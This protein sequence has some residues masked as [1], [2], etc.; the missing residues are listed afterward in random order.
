MDDFKVSQS[1]SSGNG[2]G[3]G[4][5]SSLPAGRV[6]GG[7]DAR[8]AVRFDFS[9]NSNGCGPCPSAWQAVQQA[10]AR[11]YPDP[12]YHALRQQLA[13]FHGVDVGRVLL[14]ASASEFIFRITGWV[15]QRGGR[16]VSLPRHAYGDYAHAAQA[17]G[18]K[19]VS[20]PN[21]ADLVWACEPSSPLGHAHAP[22]P[23]GFSS[24]TVLDCA[25]APLRLSGAP[26]LTE[27]QRDQVWQ[28]WTPNKAMGL[29][30]VRG[31]YVIAPHG[32]HNSAAALERLCPSWPLGAQGVALLQAWVQPEAQA[33]LAQSLITL[34]GWKSRHIAQLEALGWTCQPSEAN[35]F[36]AQPPHPV[37]VNALRD[38]GIQL[39]DATS[40]GL[41]G[42]YRLGVLAPLAQEALAAGLAGSL[43]SAVF[44]AG[45][46][47]GASH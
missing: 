47:P 2:N 45:V 30:G 12:S 6:H 16:H 41:P 42:Q 13:A 17:W 18:L 22:W 46:S 20:Q 26:S 43:T 34:A 27:S 19:P 35:F 11:H 9:T 8:G 25:Y 38:A 28:L 31:A 44:V 23:R 37:D 5:S 24:P 36:C 33:W 14:A 7:P 3:S 21:D 40:F 32:A 39:R 1:S 4:N 15:V 10:D 29:T